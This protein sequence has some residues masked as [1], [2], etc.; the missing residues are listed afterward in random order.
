MFLK[1][2]SSWPLTWITRALTILLTM[3]LLRTTLD[4]FLLV[5]TNTTYWDFDLFSNTSYVLTASKFKQNINFLRASG[6]T[7]F[8]EEYLQCGTISQLIL[9]CRHPSIRLK[10]ILKNTCYKLLTFN[11]VKLKNQLIQTSYISLALQLLAIFTTF[12]FNLF[13]L[14]LLLCSLRFFCFRLLFLF[15]L[16]SCVIYR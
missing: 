4:S 16:F 8:S 15:L 6:W 12:C 13:Y 1:V 5:V 10:F 3:K 9:Y 7:L 11:K 2:S 14:C